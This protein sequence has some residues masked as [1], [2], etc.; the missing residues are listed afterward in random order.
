L[1]DQDEHHGDHQNSLISIGGDNDRVPCGFEIGA[2]T[3]RN[4][5]SAGHEATTM[6]GSRHAGWKRRAKS[7]VGGPVGSD[8]QNGGDSFTVLSK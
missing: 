2:S 4:F 5:I 7:F 3:L 8:I 1:E 6:S